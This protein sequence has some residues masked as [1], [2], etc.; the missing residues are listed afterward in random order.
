MPHSLQTEG[1]GQNVTRNCKDNIR[2]EWIFRDI[3]IMTKRLFKFLHHDG[4]ITQ[5]SHVHDRAS[6]PSQTSKAF[7]PKV[8]EFKV[9]IFVFER[10]FL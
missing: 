2:F 10:N 9:I 8:R 7:F 4:Y 1:T 5:S 6:S 3:Q